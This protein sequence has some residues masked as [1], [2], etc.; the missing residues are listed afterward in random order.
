MIML[1]HIK[2]G[3]V[4]Y[5]LLC[6]RGKLPARKTTINYLC[7]SAAIMSFFFPRV[8]ASLYLYSDFKQ[9]FRPLLVSTH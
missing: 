3:Y 7:P 9:L 5:E 2:P 8:S 1:S 6:A 4:V